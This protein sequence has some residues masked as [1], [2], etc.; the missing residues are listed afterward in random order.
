METIIFTAE[1]YGRTLSE[2]AL[3]MM[4]RD[5]SK[6]PVETV[7]VAYDIYRQNGKNRAFPLPAQIIEIIEGGNDKQNALTLAIKMVASVKRHDY[8]W[9]MALPMGKRDS[10]QDEFISELGEVAWN[11]A[12]MHG[13][14]GRFCESF[15]ASDNE[16]AF[17]AQVRDLAEGLF[18]KERMTLLPNYENFEKPKLVSKGENQ[19][20]ALLLEECKEN[21][22]TELIPKVEAMIKKANENV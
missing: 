1:Y 19:R 14:W 17:K 3:K 18:N 15:W 2:G 6:F 9:G 16:T 7:V 13:G 20:F 5:L 4:A 11:I 12:Q 22:L 10:F 8:T 21:G